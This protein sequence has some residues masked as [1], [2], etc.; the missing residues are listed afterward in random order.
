[1][2]HNASIIENGSE[3][4]IAEKYTHVYGVVIP[5]AGIAI[6][7]TW[8]YHIVY[9]GPVGFG[10]YLKHDL[11][12]YNVKGE[13]Y[14]SQTE[15]FAYVYNK[16]H[17]NENLHENLLHVFFEY[18]A[19]EHIRTAT[20]TKSWAIFI[21]YFLHHIMFGQCEEKYR[22]TTEKY[23][24]LYSYLMQVDWSNDRKKMYDKKTV[25]NLIRRA[26]QTGFGLSRM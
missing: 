21:P 7:N 12:P 16:D 24:D 8:Q 10:V 6:E 23:P 25:N 20:E 1:M 9:H 3:V 4:H 22:F 14:R 5:V 11:S 13:E 19:D 2:T 18:F 26:A 17:R 15:P